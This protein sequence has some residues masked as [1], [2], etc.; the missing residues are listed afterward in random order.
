MGRVGGLLRLEPIVL[1]VVEDAEVPLF[2]ATVDVRGAVVALPLL[3]DVPIRLAPVDPTAVF[4]VLPATGAMFSAF[5]G[6]VFSKFFIREAINPDPF[7][8]EEAVAGEVD[9]AAESVGAASK[10]GAASA[11]ISGPE[12]SEV[13]AMVEDSGVRSTKQHG[14]ARSWSGDAQWGR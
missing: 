9:S 5:S 7:C 11:A 3:L 14:W 13:S 10:A 12:G 8:G 6:G 2:G 4:T 1:R